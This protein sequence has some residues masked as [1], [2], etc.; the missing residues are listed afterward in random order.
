MTHEVIIQTLLK[1]M[2]DFFQELHHLSTNGVYVANVILGGW[3]GNTNHIN[4][5]EIC[6]LSTGMV[7]VPTDKEASGIWDLN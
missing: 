3:A 4:E 1:R 6:E 5:G 7:T 2:Q